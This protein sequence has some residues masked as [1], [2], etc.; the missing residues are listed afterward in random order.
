MT[1]PEHMSQQEESAATNE[2]A[3]AQASH[4]EVEKQNVKSS[5][6]LKQEAALSSSGESAPTDAQQ[7]AETADSSSAQVRAQPPEEFTGIKLEPV[8]K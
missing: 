3:S 2:A 7:N 8:G 6:E 1:E 5:S 4:Y